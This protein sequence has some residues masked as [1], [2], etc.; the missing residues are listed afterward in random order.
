MNK[1]CNAIVDKC[2]VNS[3]VHSKYHAQLNAWKPLIGEKRARNF[4]EEWRFH[5]Y[6][7]AVS[8]QKKKIIE[9]ELAKG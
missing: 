7:N 2:V 5:I 9:E 1:L 8:R 4:A 6:W 3:A